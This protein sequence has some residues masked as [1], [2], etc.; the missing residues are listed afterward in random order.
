MEELNGKS[1]QHYR[2]IRGLPHDPDP[3]PKRLSSKSKM[4][5]YGSSLQ[6][7]DRLPSR[8]F[9]NSSTGSRFVHSE[10]DPQGG[11]QQAQCKPKTPSPRSRGYSSHSSGGSHHN[12]QKKKTPS[13]RFGHTY[14]SRQMSSPRPKSPGRQKHSRSDQH[15]R[16][17]DTELSTVGAVRSLSQ[18]VYYIIPLQS[19]NLQTNLCLYKGMP[20][21]ELE[22]MLRCLF[23]VDAYPGDLVGIAVG[24]EI[25]SLSQISRYPRVVADACERGDCAEPFF[26][27]A[28]PSDFEQQRPAVA[29]LVKSLSGLHA[30]KE[31]LNSNPSNLI[32]CIFHTTWCKKSREMMDRFES[33]AQ[34]YERDALFLSVDCDTLSSEMVAELDIMRVPTVKCFFNGNVIA[35]LKTPQRVSQIE[36]LIKFCLNSLSQNEG[37]TALSQNDGAATFKKYSEVGDVANSKNPEHSY[38]CFVVKNKRKKENSLHSSHSSAGHV[39]NS[40]VEESAKDESRQRYIRL[41]DALEQCDLLSHDRVQHYQKAVRDPNGI[42]EFV[43]NALDT[44]A[45]VL[46]ASSSMDDSGSEKGPPAGDEAEDDGRQDG[47]NDSSG[48]PVS[49]QKSGSA[50]A[51]TAAV[52]EGGFSSRPETIESGSYVRAVPIEFST[53]QETSDAGS[54][55]RSGDSSFQSRPGTGDSG[56]YIRS[57]TNLHTNRRILVND[58]IELGREGNFKPDQVSRLIGF[59]YEDDRKVISILRGHQM[60]S[61]KIPLLRTLLANE[62]IRHQGSQER[63]PRVRQPLRSYSSPAINKGNGGDHDGDPLEIYKLLT[64]VDTEPQG[65][66][67]TDRDGV[68]SLEA[69]CGWSVNG[70]GDDRLVVKMRQIVATLE[71]EQILFNAHQRITMEWLCAS[72]DPVLITALG[73]FET[74]HDW[75]ELKN[76]LNHL[77]NAER[78]TKIEPD[79]NKQEVT[80]PKILK[81]CARL[82]DSSN[83]APCQ[84]QRLLA[85][86]AAGDANVEAI[87]SKFMK[88]NNFEEFV[89]TIT[90]FF[91]EKTPRQSRDERQKWK[92][93]EAREEVETIKPGSRLMNKLTGKRPAAP[94]PATLAW[95]PEPSTNATRGGLEVVPELEEKFEQKKDDTTNDENNEDDDEETGDQHSECMPWLLTSYPDISQSPEFSVGFARLVE[96]LMKEGAVTK[97]QAHKLQEYYERNTANIR[98]AL[99]THRGAVNTKE[100]KKTLRRIV[101]ETPTPTKPGELMMESQQKELKTNR[102]TSTASSL[103]AERAS[104]ASENAYG[105]EKKGKTKYLMERMVKDNRALKEQN[106]TSALIG[107]NHPQPHPLTESANGN[108]RG[109]IGDPLSPTPFESD[110][111]DQR[112]RQQCH[113]LSSPGELNTLLHTIKE[114]RPED[115]SGDSQRSPSSV[116]LAP[117]SGDQEDDGGNNPVQTNRNHKQ[118]DED[119]PADRSNKS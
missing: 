23:P 88:N 113:P 58:I 114:T 39:T 115:I 42:S 11:Y 22:N 28:S 103:E 4:E 54:Y 109:S 43:A 119:D 96:E 82:D 107:K 10:L 14:A 117:F 56:S 87:F 41:L 93:S 36:G 20:C 97:E 89:E 26:T 100:L 67:H 50:K 78:F 112:Q 101:T 80:I 8:P 66:D 90:P 30:L 63:P 53:R 73:R 70:E 44:L 105:G 61:T 57:G 60:A 18:P 95:Q 91:M 2:E 64:R 5:P 1:L 13:P 118:N 65:S 3:N 92:L 108:S 35:N 94:A 85:M 37:L 40:L 6:Y 79:A 75:E 81:T 71:R 98:G 99:T 69:N 31:Y 24:G 62:R 32:V 48:S 74:E 68:S 76:T 38:D 116:G 45:N 59:V 46:K 110:R 9:Q 111:D 72:K 106:L 55:I 49:K 84:I 7:G 16:K 104:E 17:R 52:E 15:S 33:I 102:P 34:V 12:L 19:S 47:E 86:I 51:A 29:C 77:L 21:D 25:Y 27:T 83:L